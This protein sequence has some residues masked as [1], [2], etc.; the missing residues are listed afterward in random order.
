MP[1]S[2]A[3]LLAGAV[4]LAGCTPAEEPAPAPAPP[5]PVTTEPAS[6]PSDSAKPDPGAGTPAPEPAEERDPLRGRTTP[7]LAVGRHL[8]L[9]TVVRETSS[10]NGDSLLGGGLAQRRPLRQVHQ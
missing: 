3:F 7:G 1:K 9:G 8:G 10:T 4:A 2:L 6:P 5:A